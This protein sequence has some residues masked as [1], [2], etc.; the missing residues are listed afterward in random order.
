MILLNINISELNANDH[1]FI[2]NRKLIHIMSKEEF[3]DSWLYLDYLK[4]KQSVQ[5]LV[6][7]Q[8][9][10]NQISN[11]QL[12]MVIKE[13][14]NLPTNQ[15][16][17]IQN[18]PLTILT[19]IQAITEYVNYLSD[20]MTTYDITDINV[21]VDELKICDNCKNNGVNICNPN[22]DQQHYKCNCWKIINPDQ[23]GE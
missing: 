3:F 17:F 6:A 18:I 19:H 12:L 13:G 4:D 20:K 23:Q 22:R 5:L 21:I 7:K 15:T 10:Q 1:L 11:E 16:S 2:M 8:V 9:M 14:L